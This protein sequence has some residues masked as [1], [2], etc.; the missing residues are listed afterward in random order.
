[1][2]RPDAEMDDATRR[3]LLATVYK[4]FWRVAK[5]IEADDLIQDGM[6]CYYR[7]RQKYLGQRT[8]G[9]INSTFK[10][11]FKNHIHDLANQRSRN[12]KETRFTELVTIDAPDTVIENLLPA[13]YE[14]QSFNAMVNEA[15]ALV[16]ELVKLFATDEGR[17]RLRAVYRVRANGRR[18]TTNERLQR[19][20]GVGPNVDCVAL[21]QG[22][23]TVGQ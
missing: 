20:V 17:Q 7:V 8:R 18:E 4:E 11:S 21:L 19:L 12:P 13:E 10:R 15:P 1:M 9:H 2:R 3:W 23:F 16:R 5:W 6:V 14:Q 22:Y